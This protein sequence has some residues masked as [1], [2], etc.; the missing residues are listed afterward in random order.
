MSDPKVKVSN[1]KEEV[2]LQ[3]AVLEGELARGL[4]VSTEV[5]SLPSK[6]GCGMVCGAKEQRLTHKI[7]SFT[8]PIPIT[9]GQVR[10]NSADELIGKPIMKQ[11]LNDIF[12]EYSNERE[13]NSQSNKFLSFG[14]SSMK[15]LD[16]NSQLSYRSTSSLNILSNRSYTYLSS[17][18]NNGSGVL[19]SLRSN[20]DGGYYGSFRSLNKGFSQFATDLNTSSKSLFNSFTS[21]FN[22]ICSCPGFISVCKN[23]KVKTIEQETVPSDSDFAESDF[24]SEDADLT[25]AQEEQS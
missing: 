4:Y 10:L 18:V 11:R 16:V 9:A 24:E 7:H 13:L 3:N 1:V 5:E 14:V 15:G 8:R 21:L 25:V 23:N 20:R 22:G 19:E 2:D 6:Q 12:T 17:I